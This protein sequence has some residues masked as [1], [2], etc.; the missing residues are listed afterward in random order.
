MKN[1]CEYCEKEFDTKN[2]LIHHYFSHLMNNEYI[3]PIIEYNFIEE[4]GIITTC[5]GFRESYN[6]LGIA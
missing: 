6:G 4:I 3:E 1:I 2:K 5:C